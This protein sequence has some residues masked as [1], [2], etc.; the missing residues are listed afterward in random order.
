MRLAISA[1]EVASQKQ[2]YLTSAIRVRK[3]NPQSINTDF[4]DDNLAVIEHAY[5]ASRAVMFTMLL[6]SF[7]WPKIARNFFV[8]ELVSQFWVFLLPYVEH[9][10]QVSITFHYLYI[11]TLSVSVFQPKLDFVG[12]SVYVVFYMFA[13]SFVYKGVSSV[14]I[15]LL[16]L[17]KTF[18]ALTCIIFYH[19]LVVKLC[20]LAT[21]RDL[22]KSGHLQFV[23]N[24]KEGIVI[25]RNQFKNV[26]L[27]NE[28]A[29]KLLQLPTNAN[30]DG[31]DDD[32][33]MLRKVILV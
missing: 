10:L 2:I 11:S 28:A 25:M 17:P 9:E 18:L 15:I 20:K 1:I 3:N 13:Q 19:F 31:K 14:T 24:F 26:K 6:I 4:F 29:I 8:A 30:Q 16:T 23:H 5:Y 12:M 32:P 7:K 27:I 33:D 22:F 21:E